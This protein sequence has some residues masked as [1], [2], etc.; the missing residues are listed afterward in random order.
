MSR[1]IKYSDEPIGDPKVVR[2][3]LPSP[4]ELAFREEDVKITITLSK[5]SVDFFKD[6]AAESETQYQRMIR[7][8]LDAYVEAHSDAPNS[9]PLRTSRKRAAS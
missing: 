7:R 2:D 4:E 5:R 9:R 6:K 3:F 1:R 8:L